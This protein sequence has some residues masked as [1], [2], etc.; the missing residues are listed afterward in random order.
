MPFATRTMTRPL[1]R[2]PHARAPRRSLVVT[3][4]GTGSTLAAQLNGWAFQPRIYLSFDGPTSANPAWLDVTGWVDATQGISINPGRADGLSDVNATTTTLTVDNSDGRWVAGNPSGAWCGLIRKG[5]WLRVDMLPLSGIVSRRF[6]GYITTLPLA[7]SG[8]Y[9]S[10]QIT[11]SDQYV[12]LTQ[13][14]KLKTAIIEE[15]LS[16]PVGSQYITGYWPLHEPAGAQFA[17]DVSGQAPAGA[18]ALQIRSHGVSAGG[19]LTWSGTPAPGFDQVSTV[20]FAPSGTLLAANGGGTTGSY[21]NGS[22]LQGTVTLTAVTQITCWIQTTSLNQPIWSWS[23]PTANYA[24]GLQLD[25]AGYAALWQG[26]LTSSATTRTGAFIMS[27]QSH[28]PLHDGVWHQIS[29][30][31]QTIAATGYMGQPYYSVTVD[32]A[33][34]NYEFTA[35][36]PV[37]GFCP[38]ANLSRFL[39]GTAEGWTGDA[40]TTGYAMFIGS[41]SDLVV[42]QFPIASENPNYYSP[43]IASSTGHAGESTGLRISRLAAYAGLPAPTASFTLPGTTLPAYMPSLGTS[44]A[45]NVGATA[46]PVGVQAVNG[47]NPLDALRAVARTENM[48]L[49][50]DAYGRITLQP[51]TLRQNPT[52]AITITSE[53]DLDPSTDWADDFQYLIN[54]AQITPSG[55]GQ[56][57]VDNGGAASQALYGTYATPL[58]TVSLNSAEAVSLGA[59]VIGSSASPG[60]RPAPLACEV[61]TL[62][63]QSRYGAAWYDAVL[64]MTISS[65]IQVQ[66]WTAQSPYGAG[67][68]STHVIEGWTETIGEGQ[69]LFAWTTSAPQGPT[70]QL[71]SPTLGLLDDPNLTLAY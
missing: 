33:E 44:T 69:H 56:I 35:T 18:Q 16:D 15:W 39:I 17:S 64:A 13:A 5:A 25:S 30:R 40:Q 37:L 2:R 26:P 27:G 52:P 19:G 66:G 9:G 49:Y 28:Y 1:P 65:V 22:Y 4:K 36:T 10:S 47:A 61:A 67:G 3:P 62:A 46:H 7:I 58:D 57:T 51:S 50:V 34:V 68:T 63:V 53:A 29:I 11:A 43:Y 23:D 55:Q 21:P 32:G 70:I 6:T 71:D 45:V 20:A 48:P 38:P 12:P 54:E 14:P 59:A 24:F 60:P 8:L 42:H 41:I 31:V